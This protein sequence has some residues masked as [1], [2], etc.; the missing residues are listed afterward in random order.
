[1]ALGIT[2]M[3]KKLADRVLDVDSTQLPREQYRAIGGFLEKHRFSTEF[4][5][6]KS[7]VQELKKKHVVDSITVS[8]NNGSLLVSSDGSSL[9]E[10]V[11]GSALYSYIR[12]EI[13][14]SETVVIQ[15]SK[16]WHM[17]YPFNEK[18]YIVK[19][20]SALNNI[21]LKAIAREVEQ[22]LEKSRY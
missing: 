10:A 3:L 17:L 9:K 7:M 16:T 20:G 11:V 15:G 1:M 19:S 13:P 21:E 22:F 14:K 4:E 5:D 6:L 18:I 8:Y 12:S 2:S